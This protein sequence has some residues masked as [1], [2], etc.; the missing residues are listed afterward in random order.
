MATR[1]ANH[2]LSWLPD[3]LG[4]ILSLEWVVKLRFT[5]VRYLSSREIWILV[6]I[7]FLYLAREN[8]LGDYKDGRNCDA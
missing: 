8:A 7:K 5:K 2:G 1:Y 6:Q 3:C 4:S